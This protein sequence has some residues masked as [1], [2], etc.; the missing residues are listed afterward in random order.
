MDK[1]ELFT[2]EAGGIIKHDDFGYYVEH[3][4]GSVK[5]FNLAPNEVGGL[6]LVITDFKSDRI[7]VT[8]KR[9]T[10]ACNP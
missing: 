4:D 1:I 2:V 9:I 10:P 5:R 3:S 7:D 8:T 6:D